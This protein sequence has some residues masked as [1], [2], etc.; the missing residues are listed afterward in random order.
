MSG[1]FS[2][3]LVKRKWKGC[4][5]C[6]LLFQWIFSEYLWQKKIMLSGCSGKDFGRLA[7]TTCQGCQKKSICPEI[8][9]E[10]FFLKK[11]L[12]KNLFRRWSEKVWESWQ[13]VF[14]RTIKTSFHVTGGT[15]KETYFL[16]PEKSNV[17]CLVERRTKKFGS[18]AKDADSTVKSAFC[19]SRRHCSRKSIY[20]S[21]KMNFSFESSEIEYAEDFGVA[22]YVPQER[23]EDN[24]FQNKVDSKCFF[25]T[26]PR[27]VRQRCRNC[28][29]LLKKNVL[30]WHYR[31][32]D[33]VRKHSFPDFQTVEHRQGCGNWTLH[34]KRKNRGIFFVFN[35]RLFWY[36][37]LDF[38]QKKYF[39]H[40]LSRELWIL[41]SLL[42]EDFFNILFF[43]LGNK[44]F[45]I[46][47][48]WKNCPD[49]GCRNCFL[50][51]R[52]KLLWV[53]DRKIYR[54]LMFLNKEQKQFTILAEKICQRCQIN[55]LFVRR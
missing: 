15:I 2:D 32:K 16:F 8:K 24:L 44:N 33:D 36:A 49:Y 10:C 47:T 37:L 41:D 11:R 17:I 9:P 35:K 21:S 55:S 5:N 43:L 22:F 38:E 23:L 7:G 34:V 18:L 20:S 42:P 39:W 51:V 26:W 31:K 28:F 48:F 6:F 25:R 46:R 53:S 27:N 13:W 50:N 4:R 3:I 12:D 1:S 54:G 19:E 30:R 14:D 45:S 40:F 52:R 29:L